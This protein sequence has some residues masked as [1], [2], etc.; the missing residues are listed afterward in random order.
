MKPLLP[1]HASVVPSD[2]T[3]HGR[4]SRWLIFGVSGRRRKVTSTMGT[5]VLLFIVHFTICRSDSD[6]TQTPASQHV[7][8]GDLFSTTCRFASSYQTYFWYL[9]QPGSAPSYLFTTAGSTNNVTQGRF[10]VQTFD[11]GK[12]RRLYLPGTRLHDSGVYLCAVEA[13]SYRKR[14]DQDHNPSASQAREGSAGQSVNQSEGTVTVPQGNPIF[15]KCSYEGTSALQIYPFWYI[16]HPGQPPE[17]FLRDLGKDDSEEGAR[18]GFTAE[19]EK[20]LKTFDLRKPVSQLSDSGVYFCAV[21]WEELRRL[22]SPDPR[23]LWKERHTVLAAT[24]LRSQLKRSFGIDSSREGDLSLS[25]VLSQGTPP[26]MLI[27]RARCI[28]PETRS[29]PRSFSIMSPREMLLCT[30]VL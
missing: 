11:G 25:P 27:R 26:N 15:L 2:A 8:E 4:G 10:M 13:Q 19:H 3:S 30:S 5:K 7:L 24:S 20:K 6:V 21:Q 12:Q 9:Q 18:R 23:Q 14:E 29:P 22:T 17:L 16:Q 28:T 1:A